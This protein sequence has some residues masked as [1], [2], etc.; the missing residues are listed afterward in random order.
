MR[1]SP[2]RHSGSVLWKNNPIQLTFFLTKR[3]NARC[4]F[5]FYSAGRAGSPSEAQELSLEEIEKFSSSMGNLLWLAFSGGEIF[6]RD[7]L[8]G[9]T[10][11]FYKNNKPSII[12]LPTN[13]LLTETIAEQTER[14]LKSCPK[15]TIAVKLSVEGPEEVHD[16]IRGGGSFKKTMET[17]A[18]LGSL[19]KVYPNFDLGINTVFCSANQDAMEK[20]IDYVNT[21]DHVMT[22]TISLIRGEVPDEKLKEIDVKKYHKAIRKLE[23]DLKAGTS[24]KYRFKGAGLKAAQDILQRKLILDTHVRGKRLIPCFAGTLNLVLTETGE[25]YPCESFDRKMGNIRESGYDFRKIIESDKAQEIINSIKKGNCYC[26][27]ECYFMTNILFNPRLYP[28][29]LREY[30]QL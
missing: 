29:L 24:G 11:V 27:H 9:I 18:A 6:L 19:L 1:Y 22:H 7:D 4:P 25:V 15:S 3:C 16:S 23:A 14:I 26:T 13:G 30:V 20:T 5:C 10:E 21:L 12:L 17:L 8:V 28:A 2:F